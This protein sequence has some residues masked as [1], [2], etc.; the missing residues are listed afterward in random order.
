MSRSR[1]APTVDEAGSPVVLLCSVSCSNLG[2]FAATSK[3]GR[4]AGLSQTMAPPS[5]EVKEDGL[6]RLFPPAAKAADTGHVI[7][8]FRFGLKNDVSRL[9]TESIE[10]F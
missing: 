1:L 2:Q 9:Q 3:R 8:L 7:L 4:C 6:G 10:S 5:A